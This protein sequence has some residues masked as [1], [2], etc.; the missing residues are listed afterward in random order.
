MSTQTTTPG[1]AMTTHAAIR[2]R[3]AYARPW[4][5][6]SRGPFLL[7]A[8]ALAALCLALPGAA[9]AAF[10]PPSIQA[11]PASEVTQSTATLNATLATDE[12]V[13][14]YHFEYG[15]T[16]AYGQIAPVPDAYAPITGRPVAVTQALA[17]LRPGTTYHYRLVA[18][19]PGGTEVAGADE[20]FTTTSVAAPTVVTGAASG[21]GV[22]TATLSGDIDP[23]GWDTSYLFEYGL[24]TAYGAS[25]P[26]VAVDMGALEGLQ[27]V[28]VD[29]ENLLP[30]STYHFRLV[31]IDAGG[32]SYG[33]DIT[34]ATG[35][36]PAEAIREPPLTR[37]LLVPSQTGKP[38]TKVAKTKRKRRTGHRKQKASK[39]R[40]KRR[41]R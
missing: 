37:T 36:Y 4:T 9:A 3:A 17:G 1:L 2:R 7:A 11:A 26:T 16:T 18:S 14:N 40:R 8:G 12:A 27:P 6:R 31:A 10:A 34:F 33:P 20:T 25:W 28:A 19:S 24:S 41:G 30:G 22:T 39:R 35:D 32:T 13:V 15:T 21:V 5:R 23:H 38:G 29:V